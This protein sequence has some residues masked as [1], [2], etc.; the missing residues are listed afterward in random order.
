MAMRKRVRIARRKPV[1]EAEI[2][3]IPMID[4]MMFLLFFFMVAS[5]AMVVQAGLPVDLPKASTASQHS[6]QNVTITI[7]Q[8]NRIFL[9]TTPTSL[10]RIKSGLEALHVGPNN[11]V[12]INADKRVQHGYVVSA[13]DEA[14][15]AGVTRFA[16]ATDQG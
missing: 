9:N 5:L 7:M 11:L 1:E 13:M 6:S 3:V 12:I 8:D 14:R 16:I 2:I 15:K 10:D 4:V